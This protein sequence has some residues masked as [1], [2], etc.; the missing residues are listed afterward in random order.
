MSLTTLQDVFSESLN[1]DKQEVVDTLAYS[2][3]PNWDSTAHMILIADLEAAF[4]VM[5][6]PDDIIDMSSVAKAKR[7]LARHGVSFD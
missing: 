5:L 4:D 2:E 7:I 3:H 6:E 1:I